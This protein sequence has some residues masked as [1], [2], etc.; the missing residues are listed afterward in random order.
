MTVRSINYFRKFPGA[1][2]QKTRI[3]VRKSSW[4]GRAEGWA[5]KDTFACS[6]AEE[7]RKAEMDE[8]RE[9]MMNVVRS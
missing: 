9:E 5:D 3:R 8:A 7:P 6:W 4:V 1:G 2:K